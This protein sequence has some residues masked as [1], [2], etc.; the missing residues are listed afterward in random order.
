MLNSPFPSDP[1]RPYPHGHPYPAQSQEAVTVGRLL[2]PGKHPSLAPFLTQRA[3][4]RHFCPALGA[5][6]EACRCLWVCYHQR[7]QSVRSPDHGIEAAKLRLSV[8]LRVAQLPWQ[9]LV[10]LPLPAL[11]CL[12]YIWQQF[13]AKCV[14]QR[15]K[16]CDQDRGL[17]KACFQQRLHDADWWDVLPF[18]LLLS[19]LFPSGALRH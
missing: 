8:L 10:L 4:D 13:R 19:L 3:A 6:R 18:P 7:Q 12:R 5:G 15:L 17:L 16:V 9:L 1:C 14:K 11:T 2:R